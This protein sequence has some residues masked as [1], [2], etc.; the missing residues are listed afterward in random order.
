MSVHVL[1]DFHFLIITYPTW[2]YIFMYVL[3]YTTKFS[4]ETASIE[5]T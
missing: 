1:H 5:S 4:Q 3:M 2:K